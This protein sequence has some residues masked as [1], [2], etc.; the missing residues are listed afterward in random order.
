MPT[1]IWSCVVPQGTLRVVSVAP[2]HATLDPHYVLTLNH[3]PK[4][5]P[6]TTSEGAI[7]H[8]RQ[9]WLPI[10]TVEA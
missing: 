5:V 4:G 2:R 3:I 10:E 1:P 9:E 7:K 6:F 8:A